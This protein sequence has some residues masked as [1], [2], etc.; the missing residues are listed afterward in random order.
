MLLPQA[1][2]HA[3][4]SLATNS[5][6]MALIRDEIETVVRKHGWSKA[7]MSEMV[8]LDSFMKETMR[9]HTFQASEYLRFRR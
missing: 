3:L 6:Y 5:Q 7:A 2:A 9:F 4:Y 1:C 8:K